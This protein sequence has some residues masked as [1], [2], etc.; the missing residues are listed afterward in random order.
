MLPAMFWG[1][2]AHYDARTEAYW[3]YATIVSGRDINCHDFNVAAYWMPTLDI[4]AGNTPLV[5]A[6]EVAE[7]IG[8]LAPYYDPEM[9]NFA[10]DNIYS[11]H[12]ARTTAWVL[13]YSRFWKQSCGL[14]DNAFADFV[15]A[16]GPG[17]RGITPQGELRFYKAVTGDDLSFED[18]MKI[19][20]KIFNLD[21][22]IWTLQGRHRDMERFPGYVYSVDAQGISRSIGQEPSYYM[23]TREN[24][25]WKYKNVVPRHLNEQ[26][27]EAWKTIFYKQEGWD[28]KT[29]WQQRETLETFGLGNVVA[30]L[31]AAGKLP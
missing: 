22:A 24:G 10:T 11:D 29:G 18:S 3:G 28:V 31:E 14:C 17:N 25:N 15:N 1:Y 5:S 21:K 9:V 23:P 19:G 30:E 6:S 16:Y 4:A 13:S 12:M 2:P 27:V 7:W 8:E 26:K 20:S